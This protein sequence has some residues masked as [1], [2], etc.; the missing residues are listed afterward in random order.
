[1]TIRTEHL[2]GSDM[3]LYERMIMLARR[4]SDSTH[5]GET[6]QRESIANHLFEKLKTDLRITIAYAR[7][8]TVKLLVS[9]LLLL[10]R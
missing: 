10:H 6:V 5:L 1:M 8:K 7:Q 2:F 9:F 3:W 4:V